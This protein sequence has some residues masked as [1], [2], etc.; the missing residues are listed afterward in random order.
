[1][2]SQL[3]TYNSSQFIDS[4]KHVYKPGL[5]RPYYLFSTPLMHHQD[6]LLCFHQLANKFKFA[7]SLF[8]ISWK[9]KTEHFKYYG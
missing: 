3:T 9:I 4:V 2:S 6:K 8:D 1:M 5:V 7:R